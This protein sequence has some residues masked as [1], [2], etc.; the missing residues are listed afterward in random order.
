MEEQIYNLGQKVYLVLNGVYNDVS[1]S[2]R[3]QFVDETID[4]ANQYLE[5]L[6]MEADWSW[7]RENDV[8]LGTVATASDTFPLAPTVLRPVSDWQR[9]VVMTKTN[10]QTVTWSLVKPNLIYNPAEGGVQQNRVA[11]VGRTLKFSRPF[12]SD[13]IGATLRGDVIKKF[14]PV[15]RTN[16]DA[17]G[18]V[19]PLQLLILGMAK[20]QVLPD[21]VNN[22]LTANYDVKYQRLLRKAIEMDGASTELDEM[23]TDDLSYIRGVY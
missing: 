14:T 23:Q 7:L 3:S 12:T 21:V 19:T 20:N 5:E 10:G 18:Q 11:V 22:T 8:L 2:E 13:E 15:S 9:A 17:L 4:W 1:G 6:A 16:V